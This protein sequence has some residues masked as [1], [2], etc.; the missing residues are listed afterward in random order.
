MITKFLREASLNY[1]NYIGDINRWIQ[2]GNF[3]YSYQG[4]FNAPLPIELNNFIDRISVKIDNNVRHIESFEGDG[5]DPYSVT[6]TEIVPMGRVHEIY[7]IIINEN[8]LKFTINDNVYI[9]VRFDLTDVR[10]ISSI[11]FDTIIEDNPAR[12]ALSFNDRNIWVCHD[13]TSLVWG[14]CE[15]EDILN[16]GMSIDYVH[17]LTSDDYFDPLV[18]NKDVEFLD[19]AIFAPAS[20]EYILKTLELKGNKI[21]DFFGKTRYRSIGLNNKRIISDK[22]VAIY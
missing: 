13:S 2:D 19:I 22:I 11:T 17:S 21:I 10:D 15:F 14:I 8:G 4:H 16:N 6:L 7:P 1:H 12:I 18:F 5:T 20:D 3:R 9:K